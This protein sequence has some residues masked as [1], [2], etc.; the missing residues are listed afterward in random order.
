MFLMC[1]GES[2]TAFT[3]L[4]SVSLTGISTGNAVNMGIN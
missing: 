3:V 2:M 1:D 4:H